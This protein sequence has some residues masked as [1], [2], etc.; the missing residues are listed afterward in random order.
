MAEIE[1][2]CA[3]CGKGKGVQK[4]GA[5]FKKGLDHKVPG[6]WVGYSLLPKM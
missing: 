6:T 5:G 4:S 3:G 2:K 1:L